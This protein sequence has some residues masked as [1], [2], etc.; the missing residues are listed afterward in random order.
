MPYLSDAEWDVF[1][2]ALGKRFC[3][4]NSDTTE[5]LSQREIPVGWHPSTNSRMDVTGRIT[6]ET[7][8]LYRLNK[9]YKQWRKWR[10]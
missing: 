1:E 5:Q 6:G 9:Y 4:K 3:P 7:F 8:R 10:V 2:T